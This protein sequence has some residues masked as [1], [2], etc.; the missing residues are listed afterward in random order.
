MK[1][2]W[3]AVG[4]I[5]LFIGTTIIP[6]NGQIIPMQSSSMSRG[7]TL[8]V[9]GSGPG[10]Y[11]KIQDAVNNASNWD[12]VFVYDD[13]SPYYENI[14]ITKSIVIMGE[15]R[16][17]TIIDANNSAYVI[18]LRAS[19]VTISGFTL[20]NSEAGITLNGGN[21][22][23]YTSC[24]I[25]H[26]IISHNEVGI[27]IIYS[28]NNLIKNN[29][30]KDNIE[31]GIFEVDTVYDVLKENAII[32][33]RVGIGLG[34]STY[35]EISRNIIEN[36]T[37]YGLVLDI[38]L[39]NKIYHNNFIQNSVHAS[40]GYILLYKF[41]SLLF[42]RFL[43]LNKFY[44]NY[45]DDHISFLPKAIEGVMMRLDYVVYDW[46]NFDWFPR[47]IPNYIPTMEET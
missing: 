23:D 17:T 33:N 34:D 8:Y 7:N 4:I 10:N 25:M 22:L 32:N 30:I 5:L 29:I 46:K 31:G 43:Q 42:G 36:N 39:Y 20:Q 6:S 37:E 45:W 13:S 40:F 44:R 41:L 15:R 14:D 16:D 19:N 1:R 9:G 12:T 27:L 11:T 3:L 47:M 18:R 35:C 38:S 26:N 21:N 2:K 24:I 28:Y